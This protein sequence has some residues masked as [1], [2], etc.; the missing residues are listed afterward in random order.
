MLLDR[1]LVTEAAETAARALEVDPGANGGVQV[2]MKALAITGDRS[3]ALA[4][5]EQFTARLAEMDAAPDADTTALAARVRQERVWR[6]SGDV[7]TEPDRGAELRR[8][9]LVGRERELE[10]LLEALE[11]CTRERRATACIIEADSGL[12]KSRLAEELLARA[13]LDGAASA[14]VRAVEADVEHPWSGAI[15]LAR[16]GL[17][18]AAGLAAASPAALG[19]FATEIPEWADRFGA[20][21]GSA[22]S[23]GEALRDVLRAITEEQA[24]VLLLDDAHWLDRD[25]LLALIAAVRDLA[26]FPVLVLFAVQPQQPCPELDDLRSRIGRDVPGITVRLEALDL[27]AV[28]QLAGWAVPAFADAERDRLARRVAADSAGLPLLAVELL[29]AVALGLDLGTITGAWPEPAK[30]LDQTLP[31]D[32]PDAVVAAV[33]VGFRRLTKQ[34]QQVLAAAAVLSDRVAVARLERATGLEG[35]TLLAAL[36]EL[37]WQRWLAAEPRGYAFVARIVRDIV[38]R[39]MLTE[40]QR[41]RILASD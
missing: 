39:D 1:G 19:A 41:Q 8:T 12:G 6:L 21:T 13:R 27:E 7:P 36:D 28:R 23:L 9:P 24:V 5:Y 11:T 4:R 3:G 15:G 37:E 10:H 25:S 18:D 34:A 26:S 40:G 17:L 32:L 20:G 30:T 22:T 35:A 38:A 31:T 16:G 29:H 2:A 14:T 33:R